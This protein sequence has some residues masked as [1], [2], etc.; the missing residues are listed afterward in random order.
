MKGKHI[1]ITRL[2]EFSGSNTHLK[3]LI[4]F[5]RPENVVLILED[6]G[7]VQYL[8]N[9]A[10]GHRI[11][12][13]IKSRLH[14]YAHLNYK[15]TTNIKE[16]FFV[17]KSV[18]A[19]QLLSL[20]YRFAAVTICAVEPEK[21]LYLLWMPF[22][23]VY[24]ILHTTPNHRYSSFTSYSCNRKLGKSKQIITVS[25][26]NKSLISK[27]WEITTAKQQF[28]RVVYNCVMESEEA[29]QYRVL[30]RQVNELCI[31][32][33]GHLVA[34]K[35]PAIWLKVAKA[36]TGA[37]PGVCFIWLG[38]GPLLDTCRSAGQMEKNIVFK[39]AVTNVFDYL[40]AADI[41]YQPSLHETHGIA[42]IEAMYQ[43][44]PCVVSNV[45]GLPES[46][47]N[48]YNGD[49]VNP[50]DLK[51]QVDVMLKLID[52]PELRARY[53]ANSF[54]RYHEHFSFKRFTVQLHLIYNF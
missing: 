26:S 12:Y 40:K 49:L 5:L 14:A 39:G 48:G 17:V 41:Y 7:Q 10:G 27:N 46:V 42:V 53:G 38:N 29:R 9:I 13:R 22:S 44:L 6:P 16:L 51:Q 1:I 20:R 25:C 32:T 47:Q 2:F 15:W 36:V 21:H 28:I 8:Q 43:A 3:A 30:P 18:L 37:R 19:I 11:A 31:L 23:R 4:E 24:Y 45:G 52:S 50:G 33:M 35:N 34:Y 54:K